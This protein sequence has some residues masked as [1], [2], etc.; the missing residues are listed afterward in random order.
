M[1][2]FQ[3]QTNQLQKALFQYNSLHH[4]LFPL[5]DSLLAVQIKLLTINLT[6]EYPDFLQ[7]VIKCLTVVKLRWRRNRA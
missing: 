2:N 6:L 5:V 3:C 4:S 7:N 1:D